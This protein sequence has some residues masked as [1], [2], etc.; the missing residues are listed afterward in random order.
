MAVL[1]P[2][3]VVVQSAE[4]L[5]KQRLEAQRRKDEDMKQ[6]RAE[7]AKKNAELVSQQKV[8]GC[9][10]AHAY[11]HACI[12][13]HIHCSMQI[14]SLPFSSLTISWASRSATIQHA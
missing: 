4:E 11:K 1:M 2:R 14:Q 9:T 6:E 5:D 3:P 7:R 8:L 13:K 12:R 10:P